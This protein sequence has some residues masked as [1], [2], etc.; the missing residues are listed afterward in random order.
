MDFCDECNNFLYNIVK[1]KKL[2]KYCKKCGFEKN[3]QSIVIFEKKYKSDI[4]DT[5]NRKF[6]IYDNTFER[7]LVHPCPNVEC[8][9]HDKKQKQ[10]IKPEAII[11]NIGN[12]L[13]SVYTCIHCNTEWMES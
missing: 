11:F 7:T 3:S 10:E 6:Y 2:I 9:I 8:I 12:D 13:R 4:I 5:T 1:E